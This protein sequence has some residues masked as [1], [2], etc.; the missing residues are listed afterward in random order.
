MTAQMSV[1]E[2]VDFC[3][4]FKLSADTS[5]DYRK[6][7]VRDVLKLLKIRRIRHSLIGDDVT[8]GISGG[9]QKRVN[10]GM[11]LVAQPSVIFLD[12]PTSGLDSSTSAD[13][14]EVM[15]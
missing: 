11:E 15:R 6:S 14:M 10:I 13:V 7:V 5:Y 9:Q 1:K 4:R 2:M 3:A 8:R 12:E